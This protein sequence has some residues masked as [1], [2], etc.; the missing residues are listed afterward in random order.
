MRNKILHALLGMLMFGGVTQAQAYTTTLDLSNN[1]NFNNPPFATVTIDELLSGDIQ[2]TIDLV[3]A[4]TSGQ[5]IEQFG[6]NIFGSTSL[7]ADNFILPTNWS[8]AIAP[9]PNTMAV[10]G[11]FDIA[12]QMTGSQGL[13]PLTFTISATGDSIATYATAVSTGGQPNAGSLFAAKISSTGPGAFIGGGSPVPLPTA[14]WLFGS[15]LLGLVSI[16]RRKKA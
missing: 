11:A 2:F 6:F 15:G 12:V 5:N 3:G 13:D 4:D 7:T 8:A 10:F 1:N 9:P 16:A 14:V